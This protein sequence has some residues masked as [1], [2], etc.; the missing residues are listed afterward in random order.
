MESY[1]RRPQSRGR[2]QYVNVREQLREL[3]LDQPPHAH[4]LQ[5]ICRADLQA[6]LQP[7]NLLRVGQLLDPAA[8]D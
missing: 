3:A 2:Q 6:R 1:W 4:C 7:R 5:V 8:F